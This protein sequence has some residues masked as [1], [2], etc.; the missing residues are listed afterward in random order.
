MVMD[1]PG[2]RFP[3]KFMHRE[4]SEQ[5]KINLFDEGD[6]FYACELEVN[7]TLYRYVYFVRMFV[8]FSVLCPYVYLSF[9]F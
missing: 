8:I 6:V 5:I 1:S 4:G 9:R 2:T 3:V 7:A